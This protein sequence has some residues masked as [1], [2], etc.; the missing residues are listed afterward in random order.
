MITF[1]ADNNGLPDSSGEYTGA[2]LT[3]PDMPRD[4]TICA[5][6]MV[7]AWT[8]VYSS[9]NLFTLYGGFDNWWGRVKLFAARKYTE[10]EV[11]LGKV[12][13][14][15]KSDNLLFPLTWTRVCVSLDTVTGMVQIIYN[16]NILEERVYQDALDVD[17]WRP[18]DLD[19]V[20]GVLSMSC[21]SGRCL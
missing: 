20:V 16:G 15:A 4:F 5:A 13:V 17:V 21:S 12:F 1:S 10:V 7:Q 9:A 3:K 11:N 19:I 8:T 14:K 18:D 6:Y 2:S